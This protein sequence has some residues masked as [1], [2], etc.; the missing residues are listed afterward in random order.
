M[1]QP[2][3]VASVPITEGLSSGSHIL[4]SLLSVWILSSLCS[5]WVRCRSDMKPNLNTKSM[6][7]TSSMSWSIFR[8][9][10][11]WW[12]YQ[13]EGPTSERKY[14]SG[15]MLTCNRHN[16]LLAQHP[17]DHFPLF[18]LHEPQETHTP[19]IKAGSRMSTTQFRTIKYD[20]NSAGR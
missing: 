4:T 12:S 15:L 16:W 18:L 7:K 6:M 8:Q 2:G 10:C 20:G 17:F 13:L 11:S 19:E 14:L 1:S 5:L 9:T 3:S